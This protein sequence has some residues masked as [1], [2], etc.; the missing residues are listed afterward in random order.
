MCE[1]SIKYSASGRFMSALTASC[2]GLN[3][4]FADEKSSCCSWPSVS[5]GVRRVDSSLTLE[6]PEPSDACDMPELPR[7]RHPGG[8]EHS[9]DPAM[10]LHSPEISWRVVSAGVRS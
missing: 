2:A 3:A 6:V 8:D 9:A 4:A 1:L 5:I 7:E 10:R